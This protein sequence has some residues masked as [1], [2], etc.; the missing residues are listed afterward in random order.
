MVQ[1]PQWG[2]SP[3]WQPQPEDVAI[4]LGPTHPAVPQDEQT[5]PICGKWDVGM[6]GSVGVTGGWLLGGQSIPTLKFC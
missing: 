2:A 6:L 3:H 5:S 4:S 1:G